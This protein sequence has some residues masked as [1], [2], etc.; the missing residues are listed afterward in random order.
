MIILQ[1]PSFFLF[2]LEVLGFELRASCLLVPYHLSHFTSPFLCWVFSRYGLTNYFPRA[3][4]ELLSSW[5]LPT[6]Y[7]GLQAGA[8]ST[9]YRTFSSPLAQEFCTALLY[10]L[11]CD[12]I[13][14]LRC[15]ELINLP[16]QHFR[17][18][19]RGCRKI[20]SYSLITSEDTCKPPELFPTSP[21]SKSAD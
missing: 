17:L 10:L 12:I 2:F 7:L 16:S 11:Y 4:F 15:I 8:T 6:E 5:S 1:N 3:G 19:C 9:H 14:K 20:W 18:Q 21:A 13:G